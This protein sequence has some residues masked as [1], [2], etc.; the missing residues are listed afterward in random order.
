VAIIY[1]FLD[2][3][4]RI[5]WIKNFS[6][7]FALCAL[8]LPRAISVLFHWGGDILIDFLLKTVNRQLPWLLSTVNRQLTTVLVLLSVLRGFRVL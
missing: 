1:L 5:N 2:W 7:V 4:N 3:I 6:L 8:C